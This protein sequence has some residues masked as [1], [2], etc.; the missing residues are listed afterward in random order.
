[1]RGFVVKAERAVSAK[2]TM[3]TQMALA[4]FPFVIASSPLHGLRA[5]P[6]WLADR[7]RARAQRA[8]LNDLLS[9]PEHRL[10]DLGIDPRR[11]ASAMDARY[12]PTRK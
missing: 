12:W 6:R 1:V 3:E 8:A 11:V 10:R 4:D 9:M 7:R 5:F 2:P